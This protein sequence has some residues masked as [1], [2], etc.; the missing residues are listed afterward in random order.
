MNDIGACECLMLCSHGQAMLVPEVD[1]LAVSYRHTSARCRSRSSDLLLSL[2]CALTENTTSSKNGSRHR[3]H[4]YTLDES[5]VN[6]GVDELALKAGKRRGTLGN[7]LLSLSCSVHDGCRQLLCVPIVFFLALGLDNHPSI[8][9]H[10]P[11]K[12][13]CL[14]FAIMWYAAPLY[15][16]LRPLHGSA[17]PSPPL[18]PLILLSTRCITQSCPSFMHITPIGR[19]SHHVQ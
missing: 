17:I 19:L 4:V 15:G 7:A 12:A 6:G 18:P 5:V 1:S 14:M 8:T 13:W 16:N 9:P 2:S 11:C 3:F 10:Y